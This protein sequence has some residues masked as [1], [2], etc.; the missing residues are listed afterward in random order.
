V[1]EKVLIA[2]SYELSTEHKEASYGKPVLVDIKTNV[3][4]GPGD[5]IRPSAD[6]GL[7]VAAVFV[8]RI[9]EAKNFTKAERELI[10]RF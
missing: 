8:Q 10:G 4:Y 1:I 6:M 9:A 7:Y 5:T 2:P 3:A